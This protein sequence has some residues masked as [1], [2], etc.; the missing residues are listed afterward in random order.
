MKSICWVLDEL[1]RHVIV[2]KWVTV[3]TR[4]IFRE[5]EI[6]NVYYSCLTRR[7]GLEMI[8]KNIKYIYRQSMYNKVVE[9]C[10]HDICFGLKSSKLN[11]EH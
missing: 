7:W 1:E 10:E 4:I 6:N 8:R 9:V 2:R 5:R 3:A 11:M